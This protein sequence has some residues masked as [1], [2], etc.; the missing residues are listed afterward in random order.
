M[1]TSLFALRDQASGSRW[2]AR[3]PAGERSKVRLVSTV[4]TAAASQSSAVLREHGAPEERW[5]CGGRRGPTKHPA[6]GGSRASKKEATTPPFQGDP[7]I[8]GRCQVASY[9]RAVRRACCD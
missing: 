5:L 2:K 9:A 1:I 3:V 4:N 7:A 8:D 6:E